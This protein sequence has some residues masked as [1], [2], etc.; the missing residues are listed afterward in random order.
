[1]G[2]G[3]SGNGRLWFGGMNVGVGFWGLGGGGRGGSGC[4]WRE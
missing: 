4:E 1:M 2:V 3:G